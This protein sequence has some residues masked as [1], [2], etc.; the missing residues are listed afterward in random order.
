MDLALI[1][2]AIFLVWNIDVKLSDIID[3]N[4]KTIQGDS[5]KMDILSLTIP[6][7]NQDLWNLEPRTGLTQ[8]IQIWS[9]KF[10]ILKMTVHKW[11]IEVFKIGKKWVVQEKT[12]LSTVLKI[13]GWNLVYKLILGRGLWISSLFWRFWITNASNPG[14]KTKKSKKV[15]SQHF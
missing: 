2:L 11:P 3:K 8:G 7:L 5:K 1:F 10:K 12:L 14:I 13:I 6:I 9:K 15:K 4:P